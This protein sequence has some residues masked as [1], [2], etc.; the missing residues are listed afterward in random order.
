MSGRIGYI[1]EGAEIYRRS[2]AIIRAEADLVAVFRDGRARRR[3]H[4]PRLRHDRPAVRRRAVAGF[5]RRRRRRAL[6]AARRSCATPRW[7]RTAS[8]AAASP[9]QTRWS[10]PSTIRAFPRLRAQLAH[11][12]LGRGHG[13]VARAAGRRARRHRQRADRPL[14]S[15][16]TARCRRAGARRDDRHPGR[17]RRRGG[18]E[19]GAGAGR[20]RAVSRRPR[21]RGGSAMA[22]AAVNALA[23]PV[24]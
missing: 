21:T 15:P 17:L 5:R 13:A 20:T 1:R 19:G 7:W 12:P 2:F 8:P 24:E 4:D 14:S 16:R 11:H 6:R 3:A 22:A 9:L 10:A 23:S 18:V